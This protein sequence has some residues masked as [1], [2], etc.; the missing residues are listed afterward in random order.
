M[1]KPGR[2]EKNVAVST[3]STSDG[4]FMVF[5][6]FVGIKC[7]EGFRGPVAWPQDEFFLLLAETL[8]CDFL[9]GVFQ[10]NYLAYLSSS[11]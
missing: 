3:L 6:W 8:K 10:R 4:Q 5:F 1:S 2:K 11:V 9:N 7:S